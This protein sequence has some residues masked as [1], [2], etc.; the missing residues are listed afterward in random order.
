M[1]QMCFTNC[2]ISDL[3]LSRPSSAAA[4][5]GI[6]FVINM[7]GSSPIWG[8]SVPPAILNPRPEF[9][10]RNSKY[11][12]NDVVSPKPSSLVLSSFDSNRNQVI[13]VHM[14]NPKVHCQQTR[15]GQEQHS[16]LSL[17]CKIQEPLNFCLF[18]ELYI[19]AFKKC[20]LYTANKMVITK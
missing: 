11:T 4:P 19:F 20:F 18:K 14:Q 10:C 15:E 9:P 8:L 7:P 13:T 3:Y 16:S 2:S 17:H 1:W 6:I 12:L 5:P